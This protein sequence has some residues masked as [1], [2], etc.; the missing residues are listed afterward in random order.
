MGDA[1]IVDLVNAHLRE[2]KGIGTISYRHADA[3]GAMPNSVDYTFPQLIGEPGSGPWRFTRAI[4]RGFDNWMNIL[5]G[6]WLID[7]PLGYHD[8]VD[9]GP[10]DAA[11]AGRG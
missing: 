8:I 4:Q 9:P 11:L 6:E 7:A 5:A 3:G 2:Y 10:A 1:I